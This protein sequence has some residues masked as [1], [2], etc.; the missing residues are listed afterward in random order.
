LQAFGEAIDRNFPFPH[1]GLHEVLRPFSTYPGSPEAGFFAP[2][3]HG[4]P[5]ILAKFE[6]AGLAWISGM[7]FRPAFEPNRTKSREA[8]LAP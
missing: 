7:T 6:I 8:A 4:Q 2:Q 1:S 3:F 5:E